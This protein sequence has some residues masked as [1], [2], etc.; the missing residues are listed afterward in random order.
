M[1]SVDLT[2]LQFVILLAAG[3]LALTFWRFTATATAGAVAIITIAIIAIVVY[4][5]VVRF[6]RWLF[7]G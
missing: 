1:I 7:G 5:I 4:I 3:I 2:P 6:I